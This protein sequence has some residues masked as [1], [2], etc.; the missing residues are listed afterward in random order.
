MPLPFSLAYTLSCAAEVHLFRREGQVARERAEVMITLST[1]QGFAFFLARGTMVRG[2]ALAEQGQVK[3]GIAQ[4]EQGLAA[5]RAIGVEMSQP[6]YLA[7]LA[8]AQGKV[9]QVEEGLATLKV[10]CS[11]LF[12]LVAVA[13]I[14]SHLFH[15]FS[16]R[17]HGSMNFGGQLL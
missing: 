7:L 5:F 9:G 14:I 10:L 13:K 2:W 16:P 3:E 15:G 17:V 12:I 8:E 6:P 4:M 1:E 11:S